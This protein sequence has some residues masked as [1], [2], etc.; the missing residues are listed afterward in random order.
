MIH[1]YSTYFMIPPDA[2]FSHITH[3][4]ANSH[5]FYPEMSLFTMLKDLT[6]HFRPTMLLPP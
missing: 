3:I 5:I 1:L 2:F 4:I 6:E